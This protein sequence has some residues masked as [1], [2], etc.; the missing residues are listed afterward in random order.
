MVE[1]KGVEQKMG[2]ED[3]PEM[4]EVVKD[5]EYS[6]AWTQTD[7]VLREAK[8]KQGKKIIKRVI[9]NDQS[10]KL[11]EVLEKTRREK[12]K[13]ENSIINESRAH[14]DANNL[15]KLSMK[16]VT[17]A[18]NGYNRFFVTS[19]S[20]NNSL[21]R[22]KNPDERER[23]ESNETIA[24]KLKTEAIASAHANQLV[25]SNM[26]LNLLKKQEIAKSTDSLSKKKKAKKIIRRKKLSSNNPSISPKRSI[27]KSKSRNQIALSNHSAFI[28]PSHFRSPSRPKSRHT[29]SEADRSFSPKEE[30]KSPSYKKK[31]KKKVIRRV[32]RQM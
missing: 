15:V 31:K 7:L 8:K 22:V 20:N 14:V 1:V 25:K 6:T 13:L 2:E 11:L 28:Q 9:K 16:Y 29:H 32:V 12:E 17:K 18:M 24:L 21:S 19:D 10:E 26:F 27:S 3:E 30:T 23:S 4:P 5:K